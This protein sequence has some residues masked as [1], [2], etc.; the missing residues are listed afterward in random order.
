MRTGFVLGAGGV[1]GMAYITGVVRALEQEGGYA[2]G[3]AD[4]I[5]G[6]SA[7]AVVGSYLRSGWT[8][9]DLWHIALGVTP[10]GDALPRP[11]LFSP[12][13][14][15]P[16]DLVRRGL[17]SL[18]VMGRSVSPVRLRIPVPAVLERA[19]PGGLFDMPD[20][21]R[22]FEAELPEEWPSDPLWL[23][24]VD[25]SSGRRVVLG[26]PGAP[27]ATLR[28]AVLAS[29]A[30]PGVYRP[31]RLGRR[32]LVDGGAHSTTNLDLAVSFGCERIIGVA[33]MAFDTG[34][35]PGPLRQLVRRI[36]ARMLSAEAHTAR[37]RGVEVLLFRPDAS[38]LRL[39]GLNLMR[40]DGLDRIA[41]AAY[42]SACR[43]L[44]TDRFRALLAA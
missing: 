35:P 39:H 11:A 15:N 23:C 21:K 26:R 12:N 34:E 7:G 25:V 29:T 13:L 16:L 22:R 40:P 27:R 8:T 14:H 6:T 5:V 20:G 33:P 42:E 30:I 1:V 17:G 37:T 32:T 36:P 9:E 44:A 2:P 28:Q 10:E 43:T 38:E 24:T 31:V 41:R 19:F 4:L 3:S 18:Y